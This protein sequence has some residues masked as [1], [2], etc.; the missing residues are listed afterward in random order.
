M[1]IGVLKNKERKGEEKFSSR[2][3]PAT[4]FQTK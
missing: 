2:L 1:W 3:F 4:V